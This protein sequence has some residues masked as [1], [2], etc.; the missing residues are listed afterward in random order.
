MPPIRELV[1]RWLGRPQRFRRRDFRRRE[2][3]R[4]DY[5]LLADVLLDRIDFHSVLDVGCGNGFLLRRFVA[6]GRRAEGIEGSEAVLAVLEPELRTHIR[7]ADFTAATGSWDLVC[8]VEVAE[9]IAPAR[10]DDLVESL[11]RVTGSTLYFTAAPPGQ[12]GVGHINC[13]PHADWLA[14]FE[15]HGLRLDAAATG[16]VREALHGLARAPWLAGNGLILRRQ[17]TA[18]G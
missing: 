16:G 14:A 10:S 8:C 4:P 15:G 13:R 17:P 11:A 9:H 2:R 5:E 6:A 7:I 1:H 3:Y 18:A 12:G